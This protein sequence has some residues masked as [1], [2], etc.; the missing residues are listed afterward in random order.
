VVISDLQHIKSAT[1]TGVQGGGWKRRWRRGGNVKPPGGHYSIEAPTS[2]VVPGYPC[3]Y[4]EAGSE[5]GAQAFGSSTITST[6]TDTLVVEGQFSG[7]DSSSFA[8]SF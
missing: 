1:E 5:A 3:P 4:N 6:T 7:S 2:I 8:E